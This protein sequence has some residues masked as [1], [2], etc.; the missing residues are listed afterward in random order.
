[1]LQQAKDLVNRMKTS[2]NIDFENS[3][4]LITIFVGGND[5]CHSCKKVFLFN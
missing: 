5:L 3:W 1:M 4:K 2:D